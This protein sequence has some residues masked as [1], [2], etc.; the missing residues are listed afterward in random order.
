MRLDP[1]IVDQVARLARLEL[2]PDERDRFRHQLTSILEYCT[3]LNELSSEHVE[4]T[5]HVVAVTNVTRE[6]VPAAPLSREAVL[7]SAPEQEEGY[8]K[9]PPVIEAESSP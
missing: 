7:A 8:F 5:S 2:T 4:P 1:A 3:T 9:V 6:D